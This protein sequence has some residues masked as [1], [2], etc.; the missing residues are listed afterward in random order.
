MGSE[1]LYLQ[2]ATDEHLWQ[3]QAIAH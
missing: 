1:C 2:H 3:A